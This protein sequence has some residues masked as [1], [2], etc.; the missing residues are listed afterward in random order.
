MRARAAS[1]RARASIAPRASLARRARA[2]IPD[3]LVGFVIGRGGENIKKMQL[4]TG[5]H[6]QCGKEHE[7]VDGGQL[8][9]LEAN[10]GALVLQLG[11]ADTTAKE[12]FSWKRTREGIAVNARKV[13]E[14]AHSPRRARP[15]RSPRRARP[16]VPPV[17]LVPSVPRSGGCTALHCRR[18]CARAAGGGGRRFLL[19]RRA[20]LR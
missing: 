14:G 2:Q 9:L 12:S 1:A 16:P 19:A 15:A 17:P 6:V 5:V 7:S 4:E 13:G 10:I 8:Q 3:T 11:L 18:V 20:A